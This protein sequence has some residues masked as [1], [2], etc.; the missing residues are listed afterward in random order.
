LHAFYKTEGG[1][2]G[3]VYY[4]N[5]QSDGVSLDRDAGVGDQSG[6]NAELMSVTQLEHF[7]TILYAVHIFGGKSGK[8]FS[9][10]DGVVSLATANGSKFDIPLS[11]DSTDIWC[12]VA[13]VKKTAEGLEL[14]NLNIPSPSPPVVDAF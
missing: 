11:S 4:Q 1:T 10:Y 14:S 3:H 9:N 7:E 13:M 6:E 2:Y 5:E 12:V 8:A